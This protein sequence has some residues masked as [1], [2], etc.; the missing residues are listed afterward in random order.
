MTT[1]S[2]PSAYDNRPLRID[3]FQTLVP[4][5]IYVSATPGEREL[6]HLAEVTGQNIPSGLMHVDGE[7]G[8]RKSEVRAGAAKQNRA[9]RRY[10]KI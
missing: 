10:W 2:E 5:M 7:G 6:R 4:Q 3:E 8:A 1:A 9:W